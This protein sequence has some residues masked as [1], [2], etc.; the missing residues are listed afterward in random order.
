M[1]KVVPFV[2]TAFL[3]VLPLAGCGG[4]N[5][6]LIRISEAQLARL[7]TAQKATLE[8]TE[9]TRATQKR[10]FETLLELQKRQQEGV[11]REAQAQLMKKHFPDTSSITPERLLSFLGEWREAIEREGEKLR[12]LMT[13]EQASHAA[14][15]ERSAEIKKLF[16]VIAEVQQLLHEFVLEPGIDFSPLVNQVLRQPLP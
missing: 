16:F 10:L 5:A 13:L 15:E 2:L 7:A 11:V 1:R 9:K 12:M 8:M 6:N 4:R 3:A 14:L